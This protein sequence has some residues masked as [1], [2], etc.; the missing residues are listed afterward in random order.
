MVYGLFKVV[1]YY[2]NIIEG[3]IEFYV[4]CLGDCLQEGKFNV[5]NC[6]NE[7]VNII[8]GKVIELGGQYVGCFL[9]VVV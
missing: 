7:N 8:L 1:F 4:L 5:V 6:W 9:E 3:N 2:K